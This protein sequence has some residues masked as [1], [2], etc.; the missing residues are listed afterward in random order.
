MPPL[1]DLLLGGI[2]AIALS[3]RLWW[4]VGPWLRSLA[5]PEEPV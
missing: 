4:T 3:L 2:V 5:D 1:P